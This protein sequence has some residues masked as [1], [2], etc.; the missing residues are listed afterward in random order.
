MSTTLHT[1]DLVA[2]ILQDKKYVDRLLFCE[3][4]ESFYL[5]IDEHKYYKLLTPRL[6]KKEL[7]AFLRIAV[8]GKKNVTGAVLRDVIEI[9]SYDAYNT[10]ESPITPYIALKDKVLDT[11][12]MEFVEH[13]EDRKCFHMLD[14]E[15]EQI[16]QETPLFDKFLQEVLVKKDLTPDEEMIIV[17]E[18]VLAYFLMGNLKMHDVFFFVGRG[19]NGKSV[20]INVLSEFIGKDFTSAM[21]IQ[22]LTMDKFASAQL[23][24]KKINICNEEESK[25][26]KSDKFKALVSHDEVQVE[27]KYMS[28]FRFRPTAKYLFATNNMPKFDVINEG[29]RRRVKILPFHRTFNTKEQDRYL[30][31]KLLTEMPGIVGKAMKGAKRL[32]ENGLNFSPCKQIR[33]A[34]DEFEMTVSGVV[35]F[36]TDQMEHDAEAFIPMAELYGLYHRW[37]KSKGKKPLSE[38]NVG[39]ELSTILRIESVR[40]YDSDDQT[41]K[42]GYNLKRR[43]GAES[44]DN[45]YINGGYS[46][47]G[48]GESKE[49]SF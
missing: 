37:C 35:D 16:N 13:L 32:I 23:L 15:S 20:L 3:E 28:S 24:G 10:I 40:Q 2:M 4:N 38:R 11:S 41:T 47:Y 30:T 27:R 1:Q 21:T 12:A 25:Y 45:D 44:V 33:E 39:K 9:M 17:M 7:N 6:L 43:V 31:D 49:I 5:Y 48:N 42:R 19:A 36:F 46:S 26:L 22:A 29:I 18:E 34:G 14:M 8:G